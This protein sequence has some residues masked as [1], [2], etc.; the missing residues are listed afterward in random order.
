MTV[1]SVE[2]IG[3]NTH[4]FMEALT[5]RDVLNFWV[6]AGPE[7]WFS[8]DETFDAQVKDK[9]ASLYEQAKARYLNAWEENVEGALAL[10]ITLDQFPRNM[11]RDTPQAYESDALALGVAERAIERHFDFEVPDVMR[12]WFYMPFMH[13]EDIEIQER[14]VGYCE[15]RL[16]SG[17]T[18]EYAKGHCDI[19][20]KFGRFPHRNMILGRTSTK[21]E[22]EFLEMGGFSGR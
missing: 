19:I 9:F 20:R 3:A 7:R 2:H 22:V 18:L 6:G 12:R 17:E 21:G 16:D 8:P 11:F 14:C 13:A 5:S 4:T 10:V 1:R 15:Q